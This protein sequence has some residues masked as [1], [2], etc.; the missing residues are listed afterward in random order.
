V[1]VGITVREKGHVGVVPPRHHIGH[2]GGT[3]RETCCPWRILA[4]AIIDPDILLRAGFESREVELD[5]VTLGGLNVP[6]AC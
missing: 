2:S 1:I 6:I 5:G 3:P 4:H